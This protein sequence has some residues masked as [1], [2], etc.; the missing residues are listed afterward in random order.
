VAVLFSNW[1]KDFY[2]IPL[3]NLTDNTHT[4]GWFNNAYGASHMG[5]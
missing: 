4:M 2:V 3:F 1:L 5:V